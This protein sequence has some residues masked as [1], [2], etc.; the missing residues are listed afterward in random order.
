MMIQF[1]LSVTVA[2]EEIMARLTPRE[3][4][5][6]I[7]LLLV[8]LAAVLGLF[9][10]IVGSLLF[11]VKVFG[12]VQS[13][14]PIYT[15]EPMVQ[16]VPHCNA[17]WKL[18]QFDCGNMGGCGDRWTIHAE[19]PEHMEGWFDVQSGTGRGMGPGPHQGDY[20]C[21]P[22]HAAAAF[23][24]GDTKIASDRDVMGPIKGEAYDHKG[25]EFPVGQ[26][27]HCWI[28]PSHKEFCF[29]NGRWAPFSK[30]AAQVVPSTPMYEC[31]YGQ[32]Y[33]PLAKDVVPGDEEMWKH[34]DV[35][36]QTII[37]VLDGKCHSYDFDEAL[38]PRGRRISPK[39]K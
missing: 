2:K 28:D 7:G 9:A 26:E 15:T 13:A 32:H 17:G 27:D 38:S 29:K 8:I 30:P 4:L 24:E 35:Q 3:C 10:A 20:R 23:I 34:P 6:A 21:V 5:R 18:Q 11:T 37:P 1:P 22:D 16:R 12:Q 31:P 36:T 33:H 14:E 25:Y 19:I 39:E